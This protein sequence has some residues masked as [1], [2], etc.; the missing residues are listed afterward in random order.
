ME[1]VNKSEKGQVLRWISIVCISLVLAVII[2]AGCFYYAKTLNNL[3]F[4]FFTLPK[5]QNP[6]MSIDSTELVKQISESKKQIDVLQKQLAAFIPRDPFMIINTTANTFVLRT[7]DKIIREGICSTG[8]NTLLDAEDQQWFFQTPK[9]H[10]K[11]L[12]KIIDPV[13]RKPNWAFV[14]EGLPVPPPEHPSRYEP[15]TLGDYALTLGQGYLIHGTL[16]KRFLGLPVTHGCIR[17]GDEDLEVVY[18]K[19]KPGSLVYIF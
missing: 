12:T 5:T 4:S 15:G 6:A 7:K 14:E 8:S 9:G 18:K 10:F 16:Y 11:V 17:L 13:W 3:T 2:F 19:L 1:S